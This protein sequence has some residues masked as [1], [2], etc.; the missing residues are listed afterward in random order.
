MKKLI[1]YF[2]KYPIAANLLM[3]LI[4]IFGYFG[5]NSLRRTFFPERES[6]IISI[7]AVYPGASPEEIEEGVILKIEDN[8]ESLAGIERITSVSTE[9][10]GT[11][12]IEVSSDYKTETI[13]QDVK[14]EVDRINSFP[15]GMEP[16]AV[17]IFEPPQSA[18]NFALTGKMDLKELKKVARK[19]E[20]DLK[21]IDGISKVT[22]SGFPNEEIEISV[23]KKQLKKYDIS[24]GEVALAI[25][26]NSLELTGG[27]IVGDKENFLIRSYNKGREGKD[28]LDIPV[29]TSE[30]GSV[31][32]LKDIAQVK[33][34]WEHSP[35]L[36][37]YNGETAIIV[38]VNYT[39]YEDMLKI[40]EKTKKYVEEF[41][42]QNSTV[43]AVIVNDRS[44]ILRER[45]DLLTDN[46]IVGFFLVLIFL[47]MF[48]HPRIASWV[49]F[50]IP[51]SFAGMFILASFAN[52][53]INVIS[54]F[55]MIIVIGILVDDGI[56]ISE[57]IF[58]HFEMGKSPAKAAI[59]GTLEVLPAV[60][61]AVLTTIVAFSIFYF[62]DG[63][64]G[65]FFVEMGFVVIA[66][67][68]FSL[69]EGIFILPTHV[70]HSKALNLKTQQ[71]PNIIIKKLNAFLVWTRRKFYEP[72]LNK[73]IQTPLVTIG[74]FVVILFISTALLKSNLV[75]FSFFPA[76]QREFLQ[77]NLDMQPGTN[78]KVTSFWID[79]VEDKVKGINEGLKQKEGSDVIVGFEKS[80]NKA[81]H[82]ADLRLVLSP[83]EERSITTDEIR[84]EILSQIQDIP[85]KEKLSVSGGG[86]FGRAVSFA[87]FSRNDEDL[88]VVKNKFLYELKSLGTLTNIES[89]DEKGTLELRI[90]LNNNAKALGL[91]Y[92][93]VMEQVRY[94]FFGFEVQRVQRGLDEVKVWVRYDMESRSKLG[95]VENLRIKFKN[96]EYL[97]KD[98]ADVVQD[99]GVVSIRH[100]DG[101]KTILIEA[102]IID[103]NK[104]SSA[105]LTA[106][107]NGTV[108]PNILKD[109]PDVSYS[110]EGQAREVGKTAGSI[111]IV[112]PIIL[113]LMFSIIML[114]FR[115]FSQTLAVF[116]MSVFGIVGI[117]WGHFIHGHNL[118]IFSIF[119][120]IALIGVMVNDSLV[121]ISA[122]NANLKSGMSY[123]V[124]IYQTGISRYR[125]IILTSVTTIAGLAPLIFEKS[126]QAQFLIPMAITIA[127][128][129]FFA[130]LL[131]LIFLPAL[132]MVMN[133]LRKV[134]LW[135]KTGNWKQSEEIE[136]AVKELVNENIEF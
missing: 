98:I 85:D 87:F 92:A 90:V 112:G 93:D 100:I 105:Q 18:I 7:Q 109:F 103:E 97:L 124:A 80:M 64:M 115:S 133:W 72:I 110:Q 104:T 8:L 47:S 114:T 59:D 89:S 1:V 94:A 23:S 61:S 119:G 34:D 48:L 82:K 127:Y 73:T 15:D 52:I 58:Q 11:V 77:V 3:V 132:L 39:I 25:R 76:I 88:D 113:I 32:Y 42:K 130:T 131:T 50:S 6:N 106:M 67:L 126:L 70:A 43:E 66:T 14:N 21:A 45:I 28:F 55:G 78:E 71:N 41:N 5:L 117:L 13:L 36:K 16:P 84:N 20:S 4:L 60:F 122:F 95:D 53:S 120:V 63:I 96:N 107:L 9:N 83:S 44:K 111:K 99:R 116:I 27:E 35:I 31:L 128:G 30:N 56:V 123:R 65:D 86:P 79:Y 33:D 17:Y 69:V 121:F 134:V 49:A 136:P 102:D 24:L 74:V 125:A 22:L 10:L 118:S 81:T 2:I 101:K 57:N 91:S 26:K 37:K 12:T 38:D 19:V 75:K 29:R 62:L 46:G 54:L 51:I 135:V 40:V 108:I 68:L 129:L